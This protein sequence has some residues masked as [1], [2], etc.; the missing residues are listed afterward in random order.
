[1]NTQ[2][3]C[4]SYDRALA[5]VTMPFT[6]LQQVSRAVNHFARA[7]AKHDLDELLA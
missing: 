7:R 3:F 1:M 6:F 4:T 5:N 2:V